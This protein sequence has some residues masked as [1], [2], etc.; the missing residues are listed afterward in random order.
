MRDRFRLSIELHLSQL[1]ASHDGE[2]DQECGTNLHISPV[3]LDCILNF[4]HINARIG[5]AY[6][7]RMDRH[8]ELPSRRFHIWSPGQI[9]INLKGTKNAPAS[10]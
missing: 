4:K 2:Q 3:L 8:P 5:I 10:L 1:G 6:L 7:S 9:Q